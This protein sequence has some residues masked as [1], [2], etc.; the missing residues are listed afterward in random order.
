MC[1]LAI[2]ING[3]SQNESVSS[4]AEIASRVR[5]IF[6]IGFR[7]IFCFSSVRLTVAKMKVYEI[8]VWY[9][10]FGFSRRAEGISVTVAM[11]IFSIIVGLDF[12]ESR[13]RAFVLL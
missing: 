1:W 12:L 10:I 3:K 13:F 4:G 7:N 9:R 2:I 8:I 11:M 5:Y 6:D